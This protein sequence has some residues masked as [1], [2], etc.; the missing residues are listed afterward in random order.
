MLIRWYSSNCP[1]K[2]KL[3]KKNDNVL[4]TATLYTSYYPEKVCFDKRKTTE[5]SRDLD[6]RPSNLKFGMDISYNI[7]HVMVEN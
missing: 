1:N 2:A 4:T 6:L 5:L 7:G 3:D